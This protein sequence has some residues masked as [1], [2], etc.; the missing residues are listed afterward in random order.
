MNVTIEP[1][2]PLIIDLYKLK[3]AFDIS[4]NSSLFESLGEF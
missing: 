3:S 2:L 1:I 4:C